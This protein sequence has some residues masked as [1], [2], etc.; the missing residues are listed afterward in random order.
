MHLHNVSLPKPDIHGDLE[1]IKIYGARTLALTPNSES[2]DSEELEGIRIIHQ[3]S[4]GFPVFLL[5][6]NGVEKIIYMIINFL[7]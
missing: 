7:M 2:F 6:E 1:L 5:K 3:T 4:L